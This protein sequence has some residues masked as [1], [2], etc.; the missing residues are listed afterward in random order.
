[1]SHSSTLSIGWD[2]HQA[3]MAV[4]YVAQEHEAEV[5]SLGTVGTRHAD[6]DPLV[7]KRH[8]TAKRLVFVDAAGPCG[9]WR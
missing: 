2:V 8:A 4:A 3:S 1:M 9:S 7:R 5:I 6:I